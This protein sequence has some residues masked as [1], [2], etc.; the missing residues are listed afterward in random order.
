MP[1]KATGG[2]LDEEHSARV[3]ELDA[4]N[5]R[6]DPLCDGSLDGTVNVPPEGGNHRIGASP[7]VD[8]WLQ[9]FFG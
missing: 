9:F 1:E 7:G 6:L 2:K 8:Q 4:A 3:K 5:L